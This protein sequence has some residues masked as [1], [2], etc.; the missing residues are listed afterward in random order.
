MNVTNLTDKDRAITLLYAVPVAAKGLRWLDDPRRSTPV[1]PGR[2]YMNATQ[3]HVGANG[4]LSRYPLAAVAD[5]ERGVALA[6]RPCCA[7][8]L[9]SRLQR[10]HR[11]TVRGLRHRLDA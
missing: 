7:G 6:I 2:E 10:R 4:R 11:R 1:E 3:F 9:P 5:A 8:L